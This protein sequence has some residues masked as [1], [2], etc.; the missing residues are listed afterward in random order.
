LDNKRDNKRSM[1]IHFMDGT[2]MQLE[3]P[4][5]VK[6]DSNLLPKLKELVASR[7]LTIEADGA[8]LVLP[9]ENIK[10]IQ[11]HPAPSKLPDTTIRAASFT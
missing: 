2:T 5:Q 4:K 3:F 1:T 7:V 10:Y 11:T 6:E 9:F 8:F